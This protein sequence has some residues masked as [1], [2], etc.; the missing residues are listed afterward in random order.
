MC[1]ASSFSLSKQ[2]GFKGEFMWKGPGPRY[3]LSGRICQALTNLATLTVHD[4]PSSNEYWY[5][6]CSLAIHEIQFAAII[7]QCL[8]PTKPFVKLTT[9]RRTGLHFNYIR[10][11][12]GT[13]AS[14]K[15]S[16]WKWFIMNEH[17]LPSSASGASSVFIV[18]KSWV[19]DSCE[20]LSGL[21]WCFP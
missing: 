1:A 12:K 14:W 15:L 13:V 11:G 9:H 6:L 21:I 18:N 17:Q 3:P 20:K 4:S 2:N 16:Y 10:Q 8:A 5:A 19:I 7:W